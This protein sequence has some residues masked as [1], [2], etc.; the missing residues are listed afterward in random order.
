M[1]VV[2]AK[3]LNDLILLLAGLYPDPDRA[4]FAVRRAGMDPDGLD[5]AGPPRI[6]WLRIVEEANRRQAVYALLNVA[7]EDYSNLDLAALEKQLQQE[8]MGPRL[9]DRAWKGQ[10]RDG[11]TLER[12][13]GAQATFL[14]IS[15]LETGLLRAKAVARVAS[16]R[17]LG[18]GFLTQRNLLITNHHVISTPDEARQSKV[19][20]NFQQTAAGAAGLVAEFALDPDAAFATS[21]ADGG[22]DWTAV[23]V[24]GDPGG[25]WGALDLVDAAAAVDD[26]VNIIQHPSGMSKQVA[27]YHNL[28]VYADDRRVQYL[29]DTMPG[30]SGSPVFDSAWRVVALHHSGGWLPEPATGKLFFRNEGIHVRA[31]I[32]GLR[33]HQLLAA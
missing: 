22:D 29:T 27:L 7:R 15:F 32:A 25:E 28:V 24:E 30:S 3:G 10:H 21:P 12:V 11:G 17:G 4:R 6:V 9:D 18:T 2:W 33:Q 14:P 1:P 19:W 16:P 13:I 8:P 31:L 23:R 5:L 26:F 20:F